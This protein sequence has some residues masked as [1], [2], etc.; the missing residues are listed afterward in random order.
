M[1]SRR[2]PCEF[3]AQMRIDRMNNSL[4]MTQLFG[5]GAATTIPSGVTGFHR[6]DRS[7]PAPDIESCP[8][9]SAPGP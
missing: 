1:F 6:S 3:H 5:D 9:L 2:Q 7:A 4:I 8:D